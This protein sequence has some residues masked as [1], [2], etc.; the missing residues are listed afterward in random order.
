MC[1]V[2]GSALGRSPL[3][4]TASLYHATTPR[5]KLPEP[6]WAGN[7][8]RPQAEA[9]AGPW[10][11]GVSGGKTFLENNAYVGRLPALVSTWRHSGK[12]ELCR[13][14]KYQCLPGAGEKE[15]HTVEHGTTGPSVWNQ[16]A[17][18]SKRTPCADCGLPSVWSIRDLMADADAGVS[19]SP[20]R[21][22]HMRNLFNEPETIKLKAYQARC[23]GA[24][25]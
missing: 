12:G 19:E 21:Q 18:N 6:H 10:E 5:S 20:W 22:G 16:R 25:P 1:K 3:I 17:P 13:Q 15:T 11:L 23:C 9:T 7:W 8:A 2:S 14:L 4:A 24:S